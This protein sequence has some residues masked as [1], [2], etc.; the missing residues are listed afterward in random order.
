[1]AQSSETPATPTRQ[2]RRAD[3]VTPT[4]QILSRMGI[5]STNSRPNTSTSRPNT[6]HS[7]ASWKTG[8]VRHIAQQVVQPLIKQA[9]N[10]IHAYMVCGLNR[11]PTEWIVA[12]KCATG[13]P[14]RTNGAVGSFL[15]PQIL[16]SIPPHEKDQE[17]VQMFAAALKAVFPNDCEICVGSKP[18]GSTCHSFVL[19]M[20]PTRSLYGV[21]LRLWVRSDKQRLARIATMIDA[22][23]L[24]EKNGSQSVW[25]PYCISYLSHY[26]LFDLMSDYLRCSWTLWSKQPDKFNN[27]GVL[28]LMKMAPPRP[29]Q[30]LRIALD[31]Y[32]LCYQVPSRSQDFQ[33]FPLWPI[34]TCLTPNHVVAAMEAALSPQ[35]K[36]ILSSSHPAILTPVAETIR[37]FA[38]TWNGLYVPIVYGRHT[39]DMVDEPAPYILGITKSSKP[40]Y[41]APKDALVVDLDSNRIYTTKPPASLSQRQRQR[42]ASTIQQSIQG[43][44]VDGVPNHLRSAYENNVRFSAFGCIMTED[45]QP[46]AKEPEWWDHQKAIAAMHHVCDRIVSH[47]LPKQCQY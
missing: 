45:A 2:P 35:G 16:G 3:P 26:P 13:R 14:S 33:N 30:M 10:L 11:D 5:P 17:T 25:I 47:P 20:S 27:D 44:G 9:S 18:P 41:T 1:M 36:I 39:Q 34:F 29:D 32:V 42:Y 4:R 21:A 12:P 38:R 19:Q 28:R 8:N 22:Q 6:S 37:F 7:V 15:S 23:E 46:W 24:D 31:E 40:L 43:A